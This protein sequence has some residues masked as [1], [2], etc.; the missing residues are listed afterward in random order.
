MRPRRLALTAVVALVALLAASASAFIPPSNRIV[1]EIA[2]VNRASARTQPLRLTVE[3]YV[4]EGATA[5][6]SQRGEPRGSGQLVIHPQG[7]ARLEL[8]G[9]PD[10]VERHLLIG[11]DHSASR[12]GRMLDRPRAF[13]PPLFLLQTDSSVALD[14]AMRSLGGDPQA[15]GLAHC[16]DYD[17]FV[18]GDPARAPAPLEIRT[19]AKALLGEKEPL[20]ADLPQVD[21]GP[22]PLARR[23]T[24]TGTLWIDTVSFEIRGMDTLEGTRVRLGPARLYGKV[25]MPSWISIEEQGLSPVRFEVTDA[26]PVNAPAAAFQR[27]WLESEELLGMGEN[28]ASPAE[29]RL[30]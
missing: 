15:V 17:C 18:V 7:L 2:K 4:G 30:P 13:L 10:L 21:A 26:T 23:R 27:S 5:E 20:P 11:R 29:E 28:P 19:N 22:L 14:A 3:L 25:R 8:R 24:P 12:N 1:R 6:D 9:G 16:G